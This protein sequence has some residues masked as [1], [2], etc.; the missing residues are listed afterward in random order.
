MIDY[1]K[2]GEQAA[3]MVVQVL[4][5]SDIS[6]LPMITQTPYHYYFDYQL[7]KAYDIDESKIPEGA[8]FVNNVITS[9]SI[10]YTKLYDVGKLY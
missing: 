5:G 1:F 2:M 9:Y 3:Q 4:E 7:I 6:S 10:H 8:V